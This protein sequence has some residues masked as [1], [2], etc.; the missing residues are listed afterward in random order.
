MPRTLTASDRHALI[1][2]ASTMPTGNPER[3]DLLRFLVA[4]KPLEEQTFT[5]PETKNKVV[6]T[7]LPKEEQAKIRAQH[8]E[9]AGEED[10]GLAKKVSGWL[11]K[12]K[13]LTK[14][15]KD[16][17]QKLPGDMQKF[18]VDPEYR[19]KVTTEAAKAVKAAPGKY[20]DK[21]VHHFKHEV[22]EVGGLLKN[23][24]KGE[25]PTKSQ[26]KAVAV[27]GIEVG[28]ATLA[29]SSGGAA[30]GAYVFTKGIVKHGLL[31]AIS[32]PLGDAYAM[33]AGGHLAEGLMHLVAADGEPKSMDPEQFVEDLVVAMANELE[34]GISE[35]QVVEALNG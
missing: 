25:K 28:V 3:R 33:G 11:E 35:E 8:K 27:L 17:L 31:A 34:K 4:S 6:F 24:A 23:I 9:K 32:G 26:M 14:K 16:A 7:S 18:V 1:R 29:I 12:A 2:L 21:V 19:K 30:G 15:G 13:G 22:E 10:E 20:A 5:H